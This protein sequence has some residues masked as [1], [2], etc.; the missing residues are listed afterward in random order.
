MH[1][2]PEINTLVVLGLC[3][4]TEWRKAFDLPNLSGASLNILIRK[5][6]R[7]N[8][9]GSALSSLSKVLTLPEQFRTLPS[10]TIIAFAKYFD[11]NPKGIPK[12]LDILLSSCERTE[13]V[14]DEDATQ[15]ITQIL[16]KHGHHANMTTMNHS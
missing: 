8:D 7:E 2:L 16:R 10:R 4:T 5:A 6:L 9:I 12:N 11:R 13:K 3:A 1:I 14:F 15:Q